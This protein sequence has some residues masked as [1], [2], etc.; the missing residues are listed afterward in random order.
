MYADV[1]QFPWLRYLVD[2]PGYGKDY[3]VQATFAPNK[4]LMIYSRFRSESN[5]HDLTGNA[6]VTNYLVFIP[7]QSWRTQINYKI[8]PALTIRNRVDML[9]YDKDENDFETG[10]LIFF[11]LLY[12]PLLKPYSG[13]AR[14]EY[15]E[16]GGYNSRLYTYENDILYSFSIPGFYD[17]GYRYYINLSY[18]FKR[19]LSVWL[20]W[21]QT[22]Y[23]N[24]TNVGSGPD[25]IPGNHRSEIKLQM[26]LL[27]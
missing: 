26:M 17:K 18:D 15:F 16:T 27:F 22:I 3:L 6:T 10:F 19:N 9:W 21:A 13:N 7:K 25:E 5:Q 12:K 23:R 4:Q 1:Y 24:K 20:R 2:A 14:L 8:N 11:D